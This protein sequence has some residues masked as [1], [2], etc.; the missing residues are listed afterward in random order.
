MKRAGMR[1][2]TMLA[3]VFLFSSAASG[4]YFYVHFNSSFSYSPIPERFD[5]SALRNNT[6]NLF[7]SDAAPTQFAQGD[8]FGAVI[9]EIRSAAKVWN[10]I[11]SS[12]LRIAFGGLSSPGTPQNTPGIDVVFDDDIPPGV[13]ALGGPGVCVG[14]SS[15][16]CSVVNT[17]AG[18][19]FVAISRSTLHIPRDLTKLASSGE[20]FYTTI[21]HEIGHTLGLQHTLTSGAMA[22]S[23]TRATTKSKPLTADDIAAI[24]VLYPSGNFL[25]QS[26]SVS[27]RVTIGGAGVNLASVVA[28]AVN[29]SAVSA[30]TNP[31]GTYTI[32]GIPPGQSY[33]IYAHPLPD[34][35][36]AEGSRPAGI[37]PPKDVSGNEIPR[38]SVYFDTTFFPGTRDPGQAQTFFIAAGDV[39]TGINFA[40]GRRSSLAIASLTTYAYV[41]STYVQPALILSSGTDVP[42]WSTGTGLVSGSSIAPSLS[43]SVLGTAG[44][45]VTNTPKYF[46][47][48]ATYKVAPTFG[49]NTG[50]RHLLFTSNNDIY[51]LPSALLLTQAPAPS[52][53]G[54]NPGFDSNG[55]RVL[56]ITGASF[57]STTRILF[58]GVTALNQRLNPDGS[59]VATLPPGPAGYRTSIVALN[60]DAQSSVLF[61]NAPATYVY[62]S[63]DA[64]TITISPASLPAGSESAVDITGSLNLVDGLTTIGFGSSDVT[65]RR[66]WILG[67]NHA[68]ANISV[69]PSAPSTAS[70]VTLAS[71]LQVAN[72]AFG[73]QILPQN[74]RQVIMTPPVNQ[75]TG[76]AGVP[77][78]GIAVA[79]VSNLTASSGSIVLTVADQ[80]ATIISIAN[81]QIT[82]QV[83]AG[84][85]LGPAVVK[86]QLP[87]SDTVQP[88]VLNIDP[89]P[90]AITAAFSSPGVPVDAA[91][92]AVRGGTV[93]FTV[94]GLPDPTTIPDPSVIHF[95]ISGVDHSA[96]AISGQAGTPQIQVILNANLAAQSPASVTL[97]FN[98][99]TSPTFLLPIK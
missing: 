21:V 97:S 64:S 70:E 62:D 50:P 12:G 30:L 35:A 28:I 13:L 84:L 9:S 47:G 94:T 92:P 46:S 87:T 31:D 38:G 42:M 59:I 75:A 18:T 48:G 58:D 16:V 83:P 2:L 93:I 51:V 67:P 82:F 4:Y 37:V 71:G 5:L 68:V 78:G 34:P 8:S 90:P 41:N 56:T 23:I 80:R 61:G 65:V 15:T 22:T 95:N 17:F 19:Q 7:I 77:A 6:V 53:S 88:V 89:Q 25:A 32:Q 24:S 72:Q 54:V 81:G 57:D 10:D 63:G 96:I 39:K 49:S 98:G 27:G 26:G 86:L 85:P 52:I 33:M 99:T 43:V 11:D 60:G 45:T 3:S 66:L 79:N 1:I 40:P 91:H 36:S 74:P 55:A 20:N 44:A 73:F 76:G 14:P 29:G 69:N